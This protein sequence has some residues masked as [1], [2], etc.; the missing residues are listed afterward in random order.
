MPNAYKI[1]LNAVFLTDG[2]ARTVEIGKRSIL[3]KKTSP[4]N[5]A[6]IGEISSLVIQALKS[7]GKDNV[8]EI[9]THKVV[10]LLKKE[11]ETRL[12]HD[13]SLAP[14]WIRKIMKLALEN[15]GQ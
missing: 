8:T 9:I 15:Y 11:Q 13:L 2:T 6:A 4:K 3:F 10:E 12:Q 14:E 1:P 5:L 7:I